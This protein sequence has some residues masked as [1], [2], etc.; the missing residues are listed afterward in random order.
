MQRLKQLA[1]RDTNVVVLS[2]IATNLLRAFSSVVLTRL[3][4]PEVFGISGVIASIAFAF[5]MV[6]DL[7]FQAFVV[8]HPNGDKPRFLNTIWTMAVLR[9]IVLTLAMLAL[10]PVIAGLFGKPDLAPIIAAASFIFLIEGLASL[11][12][13]T[14]LRHRMVL[15]L[16]LLEFT[17]LAVQILLSFVFAFLWR[18]YWAIL[19]SMLIGSAL[20]TILSYLMFP[21]S[22]RRPAFEKQYIRDLIGFARFVTGSSIISLL[23]LQT[24]KFVLGRLMPLDE[25]GFYILAGNLASAPLAFATAYASRVLFPAYSEAWRAG[26]DNL[27]ALFYAKRRLPSLLYSFAAGGLIG[28]APLVISL[29]YD[30]RYAAAALYLQLLTITAFFAL[31]S[32]SANEALTATGRINVTFQAS[33]VKLAWFCAAGPAGYW[34]GGVLGIVIAVALTEIPA[35]IFKWIRMYHANLLDLRQELLFLAAGGAGIAVGALGDRLIRLIQ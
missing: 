35:V 1:V 26:A 30:P 18:N 4:V 16:S 10:T 23:L 7:G 5:G 21:N 9:S 8:R 34:L 25:F 3:L 27:R 17:V 14:A 22:L 29:L 19:A 15:R 24:D 2:V 31:A 33:M 20:K 6:S 11:T 12:L 28:C 13:L 32:N